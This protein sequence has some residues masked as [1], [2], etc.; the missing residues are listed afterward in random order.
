LLDRPEEIGDE[1]GWVAL[2]E[3]PDQVIVV[4]STSVCL[5]KLV[6]AAAAHDKAET[7]TLVTNDS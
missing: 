3:A 2:A 5:Y 6:R 4:D 7:S 1:Q